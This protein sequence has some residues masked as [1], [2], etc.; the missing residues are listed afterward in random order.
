MARSRKVNTTKHEII[1]VATKMF[2][3]KGYSHTSIKAIGDELGISSGHVMFYF[4]TKEHL[5]GVLVEMLCEYQRQMLCDNLDEGN[6]SIMAVCMEFVVMAV[7]CDENEHLRDLYIAAY[8]NPLP[9][10]YIRKND[11]ER[12]KIVYQEYCTGWSEEQFIEAEVLASGIEYATYT[13]EPGQVSIRMR[14]TGALNSIM[15]IYNVPEAVRV[16]IIEQ[17][18]AQDYYGIGR[19]ICEGFNRYVET[20]NEQTIEELFEK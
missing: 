1:Q 6:T 14:I 18:L 20:V 2:L 13:V 8:T 11:A 10:A 19:K 16:S 3:E 9:L 4:P 12:S 5:L 17:V 7:V 15:M